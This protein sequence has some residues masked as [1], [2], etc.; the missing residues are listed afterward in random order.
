MGV[1]KHLHYSRMEELV[2]LVEMPAV[3]IQQ[4]SPVKLVVEDAVKNMIMKLQHLLYGEWELLT[5]TEGILPVEV[6]VTVY[7]VLLHIS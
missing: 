4:I 6:Q 5:V 3:V 2:V 1:L 7:L